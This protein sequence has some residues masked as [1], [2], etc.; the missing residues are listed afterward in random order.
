MGS[1]A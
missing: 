1:P